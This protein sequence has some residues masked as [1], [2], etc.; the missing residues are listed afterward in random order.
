MELNCWEVELKILEAELTNDMWV[1][2]MPQKEQ[3]EYKDEGRGQN[4]KEQKLISKWHWWTQKDDRSTVKDTGPWSKL[5]T[6]GQRERT[7]PE[8]WG[9]DI[10]PQGGVKEGHWWC[11][12]RWWCS[13]LKRQ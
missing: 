7:P 1:N 5:L 12:L 11:C 6:S 10:K 8:V 2:E 4:L 13:E 3:G 9:T